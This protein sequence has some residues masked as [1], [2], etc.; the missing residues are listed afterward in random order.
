MEVTGPKL[1]KEYHHLIEHYHLVFNDH[2]DFTRVHM[3]Q[4]Q[5]YERLKEFGEKAEPNVE[6][7][8]EGPIL[9]ET[10]LPGRTGL[11]RMLIEVGVCHRPSCTGVSRVGD[12]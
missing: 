1:P 9:V 3:S 11:H 4:R 5:A 12:K 10:R 7:Y 6:W 8:E 2:P